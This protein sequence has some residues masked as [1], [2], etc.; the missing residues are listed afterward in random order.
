VGGH[1]K[2]FQIN[3]DLNV[4]NVGGNLK[5]G[6]IGG[7]LKVRNVGGTVKLIDVHGLTSIRAGGNFKAKLLS[8]TDDLN[9]TAGGS[10]KIWLPNNTGYE[11]SAVCGG[12]RIVLVN[13]G[14]STRYNSNHQRM[15]VS[16]GGPLLQLHAGGAISVMDA[17]WED[18]MQLE[19][20]G[21]GG[22]T[23]GEGFDDRLTR[24]IQ[25]KVRRAEERARNATLRAE[26]RARRA[27]ER[28]RSA[29]HNL[30]IN[31]PQ[32]GFSRSERH[33][34]HVSHAPAS[35]ASDDERML[36]LNMLRENRITAEEANRL[37]DALEG[38]FR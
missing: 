19:D 32:A 17:G 34:E 5:G 12:E 27:E 30:E 15:T 26:E 2:I 10:I 18:E 25:E 16:G 9:A 36:I 13:G 31:W 1:L 28:I 22:E 35:K 24:R 3:G 14:E 7:I 20:A 38:N 11:L 6:N 33:P 21:V 23:P 37:L 4:R 29:M 8:L